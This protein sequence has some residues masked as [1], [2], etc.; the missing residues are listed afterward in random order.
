MNKGTAGSKKTEMRK[1]PQGISE[2]VS[3]ALVESDRDLA[4]STW[5]GGFFDFSRS[6]QAFHSPGTLGLPKGKFTEGF[7]VLHEKSREH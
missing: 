1:P 4:Y 5:G 6:L 7:Y 3:I 2:S